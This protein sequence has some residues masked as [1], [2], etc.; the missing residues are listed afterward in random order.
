MKVIE[1]GSPVTIQSNI[2]TSR[3]PIENKKNAGDLFDVYFLS[4][5]NKARTIRF[6]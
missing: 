1:R 4:V 3:V 2:Q 5:L 6:D